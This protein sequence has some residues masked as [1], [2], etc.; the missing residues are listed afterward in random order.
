VEGCFTCESPILPYKAM[1]VKIIITDDWLTDTF[2]FQ[3]IDVRPSEDAGRYLCDFIYYSSLAH[4][5]KAGSERRV[6]FFHVPVESDDAA[7][8]R[9]R[10]VLIELVKA[11]VQSRKM[12]KLVQHRGEA[13]KLVA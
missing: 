12:A 13:Q 4:L 6:V 1:V 10:D 11:L 3:D 5:W 7:I 8:A 2:T 9:G